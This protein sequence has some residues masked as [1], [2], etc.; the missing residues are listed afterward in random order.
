MHEAI[1]SAE[2]YAR[3]DR[4][5][6]FRHRERNTHGLNLALD[7]VLPRAREAIGAVSML[8]ADVTAFFLG[9]D[10]GKTPA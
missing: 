5:R 4:L 9:S 3:L 1:V 6:A 2:C 8:H 7:I 10:T